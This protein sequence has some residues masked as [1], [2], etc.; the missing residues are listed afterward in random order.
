MRHMRT[1]IWSILLACVM[2][3]SLLPVSNAAGGP[4]WYVSAQGADTNEGTE[5]SPFATL[6]KA[7]T[8]A[9]AG[10]TICVLTDLTISSTVVIDK[11]LTITGLVNNDTRPVLSSAD[12]TGRAK[13][14]NILDIRGAVVTLSNLSFSGK[15]A[16][17]R[18][19]YADS[20]SDAF[21]GGAILIGDSPSS[22]TYG[23]NTNLEITNCT[24]ADFEA[25]EGG[26]ICAIIADNVT[27]K[28][29]DSSFSNNVA[30]V[31]GG[32]ICEER[33][34]NFNLTL[35]DCTFTEN[36]AGHDA[37]TGNSIHGGAI[38]LNQAGGAQ[39]IK[40]ENS[41]FEKNTAITRGGA[42]CAVLL[43]N[44]T[45]KVELLSSDFLE[46]TTSNASDGNGGAIYLE[47][48]KELDVNG[49][50]FIGNV[51]A[52]HGGALNIVSYTSGSMDVT[53][54]GNQFKDNTAAV[55]GGAINFSNG[56]VVTQ[57]GSSLFQANTTDLKLGNAIVYFAS[58]QT[59]TQ[60]Y[61]YSTNGA[62][63]T[64]NGAAE[65]GVDR[66]TICVYSS[67]QTDD[68]VFITD[69]MLDGT[70]MNWKFIQAT[71]QDPDTYE[72]VPAEREQYSQITGTMWDEGA[73][74]YL[75]ADT[76]APLTTDPNAYSNVFI[77]NHAQYGGAISNYGSLTIGEPGVDIQVSKTW[78]DMETD[79]D[80]VTVNLVRESD[81]AQ[82]DSL[83]LG[84]DTWSGQFY[85]FP[86]NVAYDITEAP[87]RWYSSTVHL[88]T[89]TNKAAITN[90]PLDA[91]TIQPAD[92]TIY[93]GG[94]GYDGAVGE[95]GNLVTNEEQF[96]K[97]GFPEPGFLVT[98]PQSLNGIDVAE[99]LTLQYKDDNVTYQWKFE[100]YGDGEHDVYRIVP[101]EGTE[102][103]S[104]RMQFIKNADTA[105]EEIVDSDNFDVGQLID[106]TLTMKVYGEGID[107]EKVSFVY[108][109]Q[110]YPIAITDGTLTVRGTTN[111]VEYGSVTDDAT[112]IAEKTSGVV[113]P[114]DT[115]YTINDGDVEV[116]DTSGI[117]LLFDEIIETN[118]V[119]G[120]S[121]T[122]LLEK[123]ADTELKDSDVLSGQGTRHYE[124]KYLDLV[125]TSNGNVW[126]AADQDIKVYWPLP[127]GTT[128][129]TK[130]EL[131]HF[132]GLHRE[133]GVDAVESGIDTCNVTPVTIDEVTDTHIVF[134]VGTAG[135]S[136]FALVW[137]TT[138]GGGGG[139][140]TYYTLTYESNGG[141]SYPQEHY[142]SGTTVQLTKSPVREGYTFTGWYADKELTEAISSI[143]MTSSK[144]VYAGWKTTDTPG[145]LNGDDHF[146]YV[147]GYDDGTV[148]PLDNITRSEVAAI[149]FRL[150]RDEVREEYLTQSNTFADVTG[151]MWH[152][153]AISTLAAMGILEGRSE[154]YFDPNAPI[155]RAEFA[156]ICARFEADTSTSG[157]SFPDIAG[158]W[159]E[160]EIQKAASLGWILGRSDGTFGPDLPIT[161]AE[162][163]TMINRVL[164][165][166]PET[167]DDL[168]EDMIVWPDNQPGAWY[169][170]AVQEATNSHDFQRKN[171]I[172]ESWTA[173]RQS[174]DW[175]Q[176]Q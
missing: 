162:A 62:A 106:Q 43:S 119:E 109:G 161:R 15:N 165:R 96:A 111:Q 142:A 92:I 129:H 26:A 157:A 156:A 82:V 121:N 30:D 18:G 155:T 4:T 122:E 7:V 29:K 59:T 8:E 91:I 14:Y 160:E 94:H 116:S 74:L 97:S 48:A 87:V 139:G 45:G 128:K 69:Y 75:D 158:H 168:L 37:S 107:E 10:D 47:R 77:G 5:A 22:T 50:N 65:D 53:I 52:K 41:V 104:V 135:F 55:Q 127:E 163:M 103:R 105:D 28:I 34:T 93:M 150:L 73:E 21:Y 110:E 171:D 136:P 114:S 99:Q 17:T 118:D 175:T 32:A 117:A 174:I 147:I 44:V 90:T 148:R 9:T 79:H 145:W 61:L 141:T 58:S 81:G 115:T 64:N 19:S 149:F 112:K 84:P 66:D 124:I 3:I 36:S 100:K 16:D 126:V 166:L 170:L 89:T 72:L 57:M 2:L 1:R 146:A 113:A 108:N 152:N 167:E 13:Y 98:L 38:Y 12:A 95:N 23:N 153:T 120:V 76:A 88:D 54:E 176:Y 24:F 71:A 33:C 154:T 31:G 169:Y 151:D 133:M 20:S 134:T 86:A 70:R 143:K 140:T 138:S 68:S 102:A 56:G 80:P 130:F 172:Y 49:C 51:A 144:T 159:A 11:D 67:S 39:N 46:N 101:A 125:D 60:S 173:L 63:F 25:H 164:C 6:G 123:R 35:E 83:S 132:E 85:D 131:L 78:N 137:E 40:I 42:I 27:L